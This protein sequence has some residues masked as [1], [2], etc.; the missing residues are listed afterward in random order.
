MS[1]A[2]LER[3]ADRDEAAPAV[4][5]GPDEEPA[6][7]DPPAEV[8]PA[9]VQPAEIQPADPAP[10]PAPAEAPQPP[11]PPGPT[12]EDA[13]AV[14]EELFAEARMSSQVA[15]HFQEEFQHHRVRWTGTLARVD[16][17][18]SDPTFGA[19]PGCKAL[20]DLHEVRDSLGG[21]RQIRAVLQLPR[22][23]G[24][25]LAPHR[26]AQLAFEGELVHCDPYMRHLFV[27]AATLLSD[28]P[29]G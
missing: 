26:G 19:T 4:S 7:G 24:D 12:L 16:R 1:T 28:L 5:D 27:A 22:E 20:I 14:C 25:E 10:P 18:S 15:E 23:L 9:E 3:D 21:K 6:A 29:A 2:E 13:P 8:Q 11:P 17:Y